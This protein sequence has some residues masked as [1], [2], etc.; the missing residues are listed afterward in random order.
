LVLDNDKALGECRLGGFVLLARARGV[1][2]ESAS[3]RGTARGARRCIVNA[4]GSMDRIRLIV[5]IAMVALI[6]ILAVSSYVVTERDDAT[7][8]FSRPSER[9]KGCARS[10]ISIT[11]WQ[12]GMRGFMA[13]AYFVIFA[14]GFGAKLEQMEASVLGL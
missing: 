1:L 13:I 8:V 14:I 10:S 7:R 11:L 12:I 3:Y 9:P 4:E 2:G 5:L 6:G